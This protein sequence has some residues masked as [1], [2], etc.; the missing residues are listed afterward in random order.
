MNSRQHPC[1]TNYCAKRSVAL[2]AAAH[3]LG[4][5]SAPIYAGSTL[6][7]SWGFEINN[8]KFAEKYPQLNLR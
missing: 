6:P 2:H 8:Q 5:R 1:R 7:T 3:G 4:M